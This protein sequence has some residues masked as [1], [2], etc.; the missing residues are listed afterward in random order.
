MWHGPAAAAPMQP[1]AWE[2][3]FA[4]GAA[5]KRKKRNVGDKRTLILEFPLWH[6]GSSDWWHLGSTVMQ[7]QSLVQYLG[8][9]NWCCLPL[10]Q[11]GMI[12]GPGTPYA[13]DQPEKQKQKQNENSSSSV[14]PGIN[15][16]VVKKKCSLSHFHRI[17][18]TIFML[19]RK[20]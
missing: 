2:L 18:K 14:Y 16:A 8:L 12:L 4:K 10:S 15:T 9:R 13:M 11:A 6:N 19:K 1:L 5:L 20:M 3:S 7:V 17:S